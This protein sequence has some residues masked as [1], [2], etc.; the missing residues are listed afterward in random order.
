MATTPVLTADPAGISRAVAALRDGHLVVLPTET[1]Y[2]LGADATNDSAVERIFAVKGRPIDHPLIVHVAGV[3]DLEIWAVNV[4]PYVQKLAH[5]FWPGPL[6]MVVQRRTAIGAAAA[7][8]A[9][10][11][12]LR[13]PEHPVARAVIDALGS[14]VAAP[15]ANLFG[16]VSPTSVEHVLSELG[17]ALSEGDLILDGGE[18]TIGV[19]STI[20]DCTG[21]IPVVVRP[22]GVTEAQIAEVVGSV[23]RPINDLD[24]AVRAPGTLAAHYAPAARVLLAEPLEAD[25]VIAAAPP[26]DVG[27]L[28]LV[29]FVPTAERLVHR[30][31]APSTVE[32][33][34]QDLY[35]ALRRADD[36]QLAAVVAVLPPAEGIGV[37]VR[38]RL[39]RAAVGTASPNVG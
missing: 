39:S 6:T 7:G 1:V 16:R 29:S 21:D 20:V 25:A 33:Y 3:Q 24:L 36:L 28:C 12:A 15:S 13:C 32:E 4:P 26:G 38:D 18:C 5:R 31:V 22:G 10:T 2:G 8:G 34:A 30:L 11:I 27:L 23:A 35:A 9:P 19:E 37:A 17:D 14:G